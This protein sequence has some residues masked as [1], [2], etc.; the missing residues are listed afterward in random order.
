MMRSI[1]CESMLSDRVAMMN[2]YALRATTQFR[3]QTTSGKILRKNSRPDVERFA[4][5]LDGLHSSSLNFHYRLRCSVI[6]IF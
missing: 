5:F 3:L 6:L 2:Q 1:I 4:A